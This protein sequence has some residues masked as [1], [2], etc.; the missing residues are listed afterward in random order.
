M[1]D[2]SRASGKGNI[3]L[4]CCDLCGKFT[5]C[6]LRGFLCEQFL[7]LGSCLIDDL[8]DAR[9]L[10][11]CNRP[12]AAHKGRQ[13]S[14]L[15]KNFDANIVELAQRARRLCNRSSGTRLEFSDLFVHNILLYAH[16][17]T[18]R[19]APSIR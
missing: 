5:V 13:L 18:V 7:Q 11:L 3:N 16:E 1:P 17:V 15:A 14:L 8:A 2:L 4:L 19:A 9:P 10:F 12:H 6:Q